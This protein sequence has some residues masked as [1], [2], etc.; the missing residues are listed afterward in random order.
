MGDVRDAY[1]EFQDAGGDV[2]VVTMGSPEQVAAFRQRLSL[3]FPCLADPD[4]QAYEAFGVPRG[5][6]N[7]V[8]GVSVWGAGIKALARGGLGKPVGD[9]QQLHGS[10]V[11]DR[12]GTI[13]YRRLPHNSADRPTN[14][15]L[16]EALRSVKNSTTHHDERPRS[17]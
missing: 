2:V 9:V 10:F 5:T 15:E 3:P 7:Q 16:I 1:P 12:D 11:I 6:I 13:V 8:A 4:R 17:G 14:E